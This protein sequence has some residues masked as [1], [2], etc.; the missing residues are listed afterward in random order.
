MDYLLR[1]TPQARAGAFIQSQ[2]IPPNTAVELTLL[3]PIRSLQ[4][5]PARASGNS[6][7]RP[8]VGVSPPSRPTPRPQTILT[9]PTPQISP[10]SSR[11]SRFGPLSRNRTTQRPP[12]EI[13]RRHGQLQLAPLPPVARVNPQPPLAPLTS[14]PPTT[15]FRICRTSPLLRSR[16]TQNPSP[17][18]TSQQ[19]RPLSIL[20]SSAVQVNLQPILTLPTPQLPTTSPHTRRTSSL[21]RNRV[22]QHSSPAA[23]SQYGQSPPTPP[24]PVVLANPQPTLAPPIPQPLSTSLNT[25]KTSP[26]FQNHVT[27]H[28]PSTNNQHSQTLPAL[29]PPVAQANPQLILAP[30]IPQ[31]LPT[32]PHTRRTSLFRNRVMQRPPSVTTGQHSQPPHISLSPIV[33]AN[34]QP[35]LAFFTPQL[36]TTSPRIHRAPS[37]FQNRVT[38]HPL[39][40]TTSQHGQPLPA[41]PPAAQINPQ[42]IL[43]PPIPQ[44]LFSVPRNRRTTAF[45]NRVTQRPS[46]I[47]TSQHG[48][49]PHISMSPTTQVSPQPILTLPTLQPSSTPH[50]R[51][52]EPLYPNLV[53]Q[54]QIEQHQH[55]RRRSTFLFPAP[56]RVRSLST[57]VLRNTNQPSRT[58]NP[59]RPDDRCIPISA[60][61]MQLPSPWRRNQPSV[62]TTPPF[63]SGTQR[64]AA[65]QPTPASPPRQ[66]SYGLIYYSPQHR[67]RQARQ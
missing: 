63:T 59:T 54:N 64:S 16:I 50:T 18:T 12:P 42:P 60:S 1:P 34:L 38:Q 48:Q 11:M 28:P 15:S 7:P 44:P 65:A 49:P 40:T 21:F 14:Q 4:S 35:V 22:M 31:P 41:L 24:P 61:S 30:P 58:P 52:T 3:G 43:A 67:G 47:A 51:Q 57:E 6:R 33:Q 2:Y 20:L 55:G 27:Q 10:T 5:P 39:Q 9:L 45:R 8:R 53:T 46:P 19:P 66:P 56:Q 32:P 17:T 23:T 26:L 29:L 62:F 36:P 13:R 25:H 37:L